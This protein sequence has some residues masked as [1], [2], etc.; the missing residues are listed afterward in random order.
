MVKTNKPPKSKPLTGVKHID[1]A[2]GVNRIG[3]NSE[4]FVKL[5]IR[6][7]TNYRHF[8]NDFKKLKTKEDKLKAVHTMKGLSGNISAIKLYKLIVSLESAIK[9]DKDY[10]SMIPEVSRELEMVILNINQLAAEQNSTPLQTRTLT[11]DEIKNTIGVIS[12]LLENDDPDAL[13]KLN[14]LKNYFTDNEMFSNLMKDVESYR[15]DKALEKIKR[16]TL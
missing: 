4:R 11:K 1:V 6:F 12:K 10:Q 7:S 2:E 9:N 13:D 8:F 16:L 15:F 3:G 5:L 14:S